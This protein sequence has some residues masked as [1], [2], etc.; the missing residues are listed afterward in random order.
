LRQEYPQFREREAEI[1]NIGPDSHAAFKNYWAEH[2]MPFPGL[3]DPKHRVAKPWGQPVRLLKLGRMPMQ[4]VVDR[5]GIVRHRR[6]SQS[7]SDIPESADILAI[8]DT[9]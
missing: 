5:E 1:L 9:L 2:D 4:G 6:E 7:M 8:I 3:A